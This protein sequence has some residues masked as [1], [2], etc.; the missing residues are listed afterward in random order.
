MN[1]ILRNFLQ[2]LNAPPVPMDNPAKNRSMRLLSMLIL[3]FVSGALL[4]SIVQYLVEPGFL[5]VFILING[6][7]SI[8]VF[9]YFL[10]KKGRYHAAKILSL[11]CIS[12]AILLATQFGPPNIYTRYLYGM[13]MP[14]VL[15]SILLSLRGTAILALVNLTGILLLTALSP[16]ITFGVVVDP[17]GAYITVSLLILVGVYHRGQVEKERQIEIK[18]KEERYRSLVENIGEVIFSMDLEG[19]ITY[20][21]PVV[22]R[23]TL[24]KT[25]E[26][27]G[28]H[29]SKLV[30]TDDLPELEKSLELLYNG[31]E[32]SSE[33]RLM[34]KDG[35]Q[36]HIRT[37]SHLVTEDGVHKGITGVATD[38]T[39]QKKL[40]IQFLQA[41][42]MEVLGQLA[43]GIAH[44]FNN[45]ITVILGY[46][47]MLSMEDALPPGV[48][49]LIKSIQTAADRGAALTRQ[50]LAF[51]R[52]QI[53]QPQVLDINERIDNL[54]T[55][56]KRLIREN[57]TFKTGYAR[58]IR[59]IKVDPAQLE[60]VV[61]NL[62]VN[63]VD[64]MPDGGTLKIETANALLDDNYCRQFSDV[65]PGHYVLLSVID[66]G[67]GMDK[68]TI[69][70][71]F[72][73]F[74]T[75]KEAGKGTGLGLSTVYGIVKQSGGHIWFC[76]TPGKG[77][78]FKIY[79]PTVDDTGERDGETGDMAAP[80]LEKKKE[81]LLVVEDE[82]ELRDVMVSVLEGFGYRAFAA[83]D[84]ET[85][86]R[87]CEEMKEETVDL[88]I[89]DVMM[90][91]M[92]GKDLAN[93]LNK[94]FPEM[95]VLY[96]SGYTDKKIVT[97]DI[98][99]KGLTF[100]PKPFT[101]GLLQLR[102]RE[103]LEKEKGPGVPVDD[104]GCPG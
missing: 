76:S 19:Y 53:I 78:T 50:L 52:K 71:L 23:M 93:K 5:P 33:F 97:R 38:I 103:V 22:E 45:L 4:Y 40:E 47:Q 81:L 15:G 96:V 42:K 39:L 9:A 11:V 14:V 12:T 88:L 26:L 66:T 46:C 30:H 84:G 83:K 64:A 98:V 62:A 73:P 24:Y 18:Q 21:S 89:T 95:G 56:L 6:C 86:L 13:I 49:D 91:G 29:F 60:Q 31:I 77:T 100:L 34:D 61:M 74:F 1:G 101:P 59:S 20:M 92:S 28:K 70:H 2:E 58:D 55:M 27:V 43:G 85:A 16:S 10:N 68:R 44:D 41:Q 32:E 69:E 63:A 7:N 104:N 48:D 87:M 79:F 36:H 90:P 67:C 94:Q 57:I 35:S 8:L 72:D 102:I 99:G 80:V 75:T 51:S 54:E 37:T 25:D 82:E 17:L 65:E 3:S